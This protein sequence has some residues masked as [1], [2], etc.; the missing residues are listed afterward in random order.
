MTSAMLAAWVPVGWVSGKIYR[1]A[2]RLVGASR[3]HCSLAFFLLNVV[4]MC[5]LIAWSDSLTDAM[6]WIISTVFSVP[7]MWFAL[8]VNASQ[9]STDLV[10]GSFGSNPLLL[11]RRVTNVMV[12]I[13]A[14][15][16]SLAAQRPS[17]V[18]W[19]GFALAM[20]NLDRDDDNG[21]PLVARAWRRLRQVATR[22]DPAVVPS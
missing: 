21:E 10:S 15:T 13:I 5:S 22:I 6:P 12:F 4:H 3:V 20:L 18:L 2:N 7:F 8:S 17:A 14:I 1:A 11:M 16:A 19:F 9:Q